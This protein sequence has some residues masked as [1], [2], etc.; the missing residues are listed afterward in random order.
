M[1]LRTQ[2][3]VPLALV[4]FISP[5][6]SAEIGGK[7]KDAGTDL[8]GSK[9]SGTADITISSDTNC[10]IVWHAEGSADI[11]GICMRGPDTLA[12]AYMFNGRPFLVLYKLEADGTL[13]GTYTGTNHNSVGT[14]ILTPERP[15]SGSAAG[16]NQ[17][18]HR[19]AEAAKAHGFAPGTKITNADGSSVETLSDGTE[20]IKNANGSSQE[21]KPNGT[22]IITNADGGSVETRSDGTEII[23]NA[24]GSS[25]ETKPNGTKII[26]NADGSS[27]ETRPDGTEIIKNADGSSQE[28]KP[29]GTKTETN[30]NS[31]RRQ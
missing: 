26:T 17:S 3:L 29:N 22:Q 25:Q 2:Y 15:A 9:Y 23:K 27:V 19:P 10:T 13:G 7:Y 21:T 24:N 16:G 11:D 1:R 12:A 18:G 6:S 30:A 8:D 20:I 5:A 31:S 28:T 4:A 14:D